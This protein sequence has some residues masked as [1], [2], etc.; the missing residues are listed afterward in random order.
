MFA[1]SQVMCKQKFGV[2]MLCCWLAFVAIERVERLILE[3][4]VVRWACIL[5]IVF[6]VIIIH[7][8]V[9]SSM[10]GGSVG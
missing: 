1:T 8:G 10:S 9:C 2:C 6:F 3:H 5:V 7:V 4:S